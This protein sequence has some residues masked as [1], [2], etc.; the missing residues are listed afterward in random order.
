MVAVSEYVPYKIHMI[1]IVLGQGYS[2]HKKVLYQD[3]EGAIKM[4]K[5]GI[6]SCKGNSRHIYT[7]YFFVKD[8]VNN[9]EFSI[10]YCNTSAMLANFFTKP[11]QGSLF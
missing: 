4:E 1:N 7:R 6:S 11:F 8:C 10:E 2:L 9:E 3:N 5:N